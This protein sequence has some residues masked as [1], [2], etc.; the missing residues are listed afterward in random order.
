MFSAATAKAFGSMRL[1]SPFSAAPAWLVIAPS[2]Y[3]PNLKTLRTVY[4]LLF[5]LFVRLELLP[6]P[7]PV[8]FT[9]DILP[10]FQRMSGLQWVNEG[11]ARAFP[12]IEVIFADAGY[13]GPIMANTVIKT[14]RWRLEI[15]KRDGVPRFEVV[16]NAGCSSAPERLVEN[17]RY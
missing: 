13:Q 17:V 3:A 15:V 7:G 14:G 11:F 12:F 8:S 5:D 1:G 6:P 2:N 16:P 10:I 4:D 9:R